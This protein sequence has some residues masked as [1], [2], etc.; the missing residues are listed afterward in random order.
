[1]SILWSVFPFPVLNL[2]YFWGERAG[3]RR[4]TACMHACSSSWIRFWISHECLVRQSCT[5][6]EGVKDYFRGEGGRE[7]EKVVVQ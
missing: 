3:A 5:A 6:V 4:R 1:M 7:A 2:F